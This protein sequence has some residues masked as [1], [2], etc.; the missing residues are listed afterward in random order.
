LRDWLV[1]SAGQA[2]IGAYLKQGQQLFHPSADR[3]K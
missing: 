1:S 3:P 2:A